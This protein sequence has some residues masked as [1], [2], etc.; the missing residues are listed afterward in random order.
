MFHIEKVNYEDAK[1]AEEL[2]FLLN[3]YAMDV[4]GGGEPISAYCRIHLIDQLRKN[5]SA[6]SFI[7][8]DEKKAIG[9]ANCFMGFSTFACKPLLNIHDFAVIGDYRGKHLSQKLLHEIEQYSDLKGCCKITLEVLENNVAAKKAY[10]NYGFKGY[11]LLEDS[12]PAEFWQK[13]I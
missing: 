6:V 8:Y 4:M 7:L 3:E 1:Q 12:G 10:L 2:L 5:D 11:E 9:F 13:I